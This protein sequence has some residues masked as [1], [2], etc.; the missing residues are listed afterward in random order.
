MLGTGLI[1]LLRKKIL[2]ISYI[3]LKEMGFSKVLSI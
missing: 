1:D 3:E 2:S